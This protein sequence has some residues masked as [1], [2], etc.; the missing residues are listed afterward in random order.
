[1]DE[2]GLEHSTVDR[3]AW[4]AAR[5]AHMDEEKQLTRRRDELSRQRRDLPWLQVNQDYV[6]TGPEGEVTLADLFDGRSQLLVYHFMLGPGWDEG[7]P[8]CS[9][10]ADNYNGVG[11]HLAHRD[12]T[13]A[14]IS[15]APF[16][17]IAAYKDRMGWSFPWV[18]SYDSSFNFDMA[19]SFTTEQL[20]SGD[21]G[22][23]FGTQAFGG[24]EAPGVSV[25]A[26]DSA[27]RIFLTYQ[28]FS[29]GLDM[30]NTA[31]HMLDLTPKG[32]DEDNLPWSMAWL[33]RHDA[34][35]DD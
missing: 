28:T 21:P 18:S 27:S 22:Y 15:R 4:L 24:E 13:L 8:S 23:N 32:R 33:H 29:R 26:K 3:E 35:P 25:F 16:P 11:V 9:F 30:L 10:W 17:D 12:T 1:M 2:S 20:E 34:Y 19:V 7:C 14:A 31:Y 6:F 5:L